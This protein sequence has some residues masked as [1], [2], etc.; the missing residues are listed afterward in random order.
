MLSEDKGGFTYKNDD[1]NFQINFPAIWSGVIVKEGDGSMAFSNDKEFSSSKIIF[2]FPVDYTL[3]N[4][5]C[6]DCFAEIFHLDVLTRKEAGEFEI[7]READILQNGANPFNSSYVVLASN[8]EY[9][10]YGP[11][12]FSGQSFDGKF[13]ETRQGEAR[14]AIFNNF[15]TW[16]KLSK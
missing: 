2:G 8:I 7:A 1:Y 9:V 15:I 3:E 4:N 13:I 14:D 10:F 16:N 12:N 6:S 11:S 5:S